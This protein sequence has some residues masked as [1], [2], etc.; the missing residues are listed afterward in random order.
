MNN[1][2]KREFFAYQILTGDETYKRLKRKITLNDLAN[3]INKI[4]NEFFKDYKIWVVLIIKWHFDYLNNYL[5]NPNKIDS[6][7]KKLFE[8][9]LIF[10]NLQNL[11]GL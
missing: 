1:F 2:K 7:I 8:I 4:D 6:T 10:Q 11:I 9:T 5:I 3:Q